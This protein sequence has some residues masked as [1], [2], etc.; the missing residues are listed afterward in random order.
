MKYRFAALFAG[1][2]FVFA[3]PACV[4]HH[5]DDDG[6]YDRHHQASPHAYYTTVDADFVL[7][8]AFG[9]GAGV[10]VEYSSGGVWTVWTSCDAA[11]TGDSCAFDVQVR[12]TAPVATVD[13]LDMEDFDHVELYDDY[14]FAMIV[15][16]A[17]HMDRVMFSTEPG[18]LVEIELAIDGIIDPSYF[19]WYGNGTVHNGAPESP[20]VFQPD[21][22]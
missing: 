4:S 6:Y 17:Y 16:T 5:D 12:S 19:V 2:A 7:N 8:T 18:A 9:E 20:V 10:F 21:Q 22:P 1:F 15:D 11:L 13:E 14:D 3:A